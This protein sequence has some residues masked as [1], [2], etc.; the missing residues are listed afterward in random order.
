MP[1]EIDKRAVPTTWK[2][3]IMVKSNKSS[4]ELNWI[5]AHNYLK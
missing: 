2:R 1:S 4:E 3:V 5:R